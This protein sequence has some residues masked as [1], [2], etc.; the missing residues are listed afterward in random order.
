MEKGIK[1][2]FFNSFIISFSLSLFIFL[3]FISNSFAGQIIVY[4]EAGPM[5][6][7]EK[8]KAIKCDPY[9]RGNC[10]EPVFFDLNIREYLPEGSY[11]VGFENSLY[12]GW[13]NVEDGALTTLTLHKLYVPSAIKQKNKIKVFRDFSSPIEQNKVLFQNYYLGRH[14]FKQSEY[15]FGDYYLSFDNKMD[16]VQKITNETCSKINSFQEPGPEA[17]LI[18]EVYNN[19]DS[20]FDLSQ[21]FVFNKNR[22]YSYSEYWITTPGDRTRI[23]HKRFLVSTPLDATDFVSVFPGVYRFQAGKDSNSHQVTTPNIQENY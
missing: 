20:M 21:I 1:M 18:C 22:S 6:I 11:I 3:G 7:H 13:V 10:S 17:Q 16:L 15:D 8:V 19:A 4:G 14:F 23:D 12:P 5:Q 9:S 2:N